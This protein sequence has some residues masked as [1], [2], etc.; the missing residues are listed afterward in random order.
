MINEK[1][2]LHD[3]LILEFHFMIYGAYSLIRKKKQ[4]QSTDR[5]AFHFNKSRKKVERID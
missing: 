5:R 3:K 4:Y 1:D 2:V